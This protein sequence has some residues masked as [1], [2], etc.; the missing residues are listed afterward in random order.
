[1]STQPTAAFLVIGSE[2]LS[3]QVQDQNTSVLAKML[4]H[5]GISL[6]RTETV[7]D[8][9]K[10]IAQSVVQL[11]QKHTYVF[12]SGGIGPTHD[13]VTY[14]SIAQ[15][16]ERRLEYHQP[17][18]KKMQEY[19]QI[20]YPTSV[21]NEAR[22][23]MVLLPMPCQVIEIDG[24]WV[25][26]VQVENVYIFPGVPELFAQ[27]VHGVETLFLGT[28]KM[29][30]FILTQMHEGDIAEFLSDVQRKNPEVGIGSYP[31]GAGA[32]YCVKVSVEGMDAK[33]VADVARVLQERLQGMG[34]ETC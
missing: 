14:E 16:F 2:I 8:S 32:S 3:G 9:V 27:M 31:A 25:P 21:L 30:V 12:T 5:N 6:V 23:R 19:Y 24:I 17:S 34:M 13:D 11:S 7:L 15:A 1:M 10:D 20:H 18:L 26:L 28:P 29:R 33:Q 22:K 4:F